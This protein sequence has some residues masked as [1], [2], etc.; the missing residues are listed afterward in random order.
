MSDQLVDTSMRIESRLFEM[1]EDE[2]QMELK[3]VYYNDSWS[4]G[5]K[6]QY[7]IIRS[8]VNTYI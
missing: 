2:T 4:I 6:M 8:L 3:A 7:A 5:R 1:S